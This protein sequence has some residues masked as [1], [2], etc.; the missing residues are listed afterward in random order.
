MK[1][2]VR[3]NADVLLDFLKDIGLGTWT[4]IKGLLMI[5]YRILL[6]WCAFWMFIGSVLVYLAEDFVKKIG[7]RKAKFAKRAEA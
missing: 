7:Q 2:T 6:V 3:D 1:S 4:V 5:A